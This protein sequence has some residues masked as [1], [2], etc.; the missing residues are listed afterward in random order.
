M[1][2]ERR[3]RRSI[4]LRNY[5]YTQPGAYFVTICTRREKCVLHD[6]VV[7]GIASEVWHALPRWFPTID[8]DEFVVMPNHVHFIVCLGDSVREIPE[9]K[10]DADVSVAVT[11]AINEPETGDV[12]AAA[13]AA[14]GSATWTIPDPQTVNLEPSLGDVVGAFK[15]LVFKVFRDWVQ[16]NDPGRSSRLWQRNYYEH[17]IRSERA[18]QAAR[19]Y[20]ADNPARWEWDRYNPDSTGPDPNAAELWKLFQEGDS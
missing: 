9:A 20:I 11:A 6:P 13:R 16:K 7:K 10:H 15:S 12:E 2:R 5:D 19:Q 17:V 8:L 3:R 18:L 14:Q 4:R 1:T